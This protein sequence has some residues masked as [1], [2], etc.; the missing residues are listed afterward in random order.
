MC[1]GICVVKCQGMA[2]R[3]RWVP[4]AAAASV[5]GGRAINEAAVGGRGDV[6]W[7]LA[8]IFPWP[9]LLC[10]PREPPYPSYSA[11]RR[12]VSLVSPHSVR[13]SACIAFG[14]FILSYLIL[15]KVS[16][17]YP[18]DMSSSYTYISP[19]S[20]QAG[21][22]LFPGTSEVQRSVAVAVW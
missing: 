16:L 4:N 12:T 21:W 20:C 7:R 3:H 17:L 5:N 8:H 15:L 11:C 19:T 22:A 1:H 10:M 13:V 18:L 9:G 2:C 14:P 6:P